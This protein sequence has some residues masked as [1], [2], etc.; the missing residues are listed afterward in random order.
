M[1]DDDTLMKEAAREVRRSLDPDLGVGRQGMERTLRRRRRSRR[2]VRGGIALALVAALAAVAWTTQDPAEQDVVAGPVAT[3]QDT[4]S[5]TGS[6]TTVPATVAPP[7][8]SDPARVT[9]MTV[10]RVETLLG[11]IF[12]ITVPNAPAFEQQ[13]HAV[14]HPS[15]SGRA[16]GTALDVSVEAGSGEQIAAGG[17]VNPIGPA[18]CVPT[19]QDDLGAGNTFVRWRLTRPDGSLQGGSTPELATLSN[20]EWSVVLR[21]PDE[22]EARRVADGLTIS[23][24]ATGGPRLTYDDPT[25]QPEPFPTGDVFLSFQETPDDIPVYLTLSHDCSLLAPTDINDSGRE[26]IDGVG[27]RISGDSTLESQLRSVIRITRIR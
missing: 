8:A 11:D 20:G 1:N 16:P 9:E 21:G 13:P 18:G 6:S 25:L 2:I 10:L 26:C 24:S 5:S 27:V 4:A 7:T 17:C 15:P 23:T 12:D 3:D 22:A 14:F 19:E